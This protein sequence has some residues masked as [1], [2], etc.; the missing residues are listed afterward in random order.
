VGEIATRRTA[1]VAAT[2]VLV[3]SMMLPVAAGALSAGAAASASPTVTAGSAGSLGVPVQ[4]TAPSAVPLGGG[5]GVPVSPHP[6]TL[7]I[8]EITAGGATTEDPAIAYDTVSAEPILNVYEPLITY[9]GNQNTSLLPVLATCVPGT[10]QCVTDYGSSLID[11][12]NSMPYTGAAGQQPIYWTFVIDPAAHFYDNATGKSWGVYP[13]DVMFSEAR[14]LAFSEIIGS[15]NTAGWLTAQALLPAGTGWDAGGVHSPYNN[16]PGDIMS[17]MLIND[18]A[19]CPSTAI[20]NAHGCITFKADG[21]G[22]DWPFFLQ[23]IGDEFAG[24]VLPCGFFS[25]HHSGIPGWTGSNA[26]NGDGPCAVPQL[27]HSQS[28]SSIAWSDYLANLTST[29]SGPSNATSW[30]A[31]EAT[32]SGS[33]Y[34]VPSGEGYVQWHMAGSGPYYAATN[35]NGSP[36]GYVLG[37]NPAYAQPSGCSGAGGLA[38][39]SGVCYPAVGKYIPNA[40]IIYQVNSDTVGVNACKAKTADFCAFLTVDAGEMKTLHS[41]GLVN[42]YIAHSLSTFFQ[43]IDLNWSV[44]SFTSIGNTN[45]SN[46][47]IGPQFFSGLAARAFLQQS[48][49]YLESEQKAWTQSGIPFEFEAGGPIA[50]GMGNFYPTNVTF[51]LGNADTNPSDVGGAAWWWAQ[52]T[53]PSSQYYDPQLAACKVTKCI[54]PIVGELADPS[55]DKAYGYWM[56]SIRTITG[57]ALDPYSIDVPFAGAVNSLVGQLSESPGSG[58]Y[59][60]FTLGWA[61]DNFDPQ[62]YMAPMAYPNNTYT[63]STAVEEQMA[64]KKFNS[65]SCGHATYSSFADLVYWAHQSQLT[66]ACQGVAWQVMSYWN[67]AATSVANLTQRILDYNLVEHILNA[68]ALIVWQGQANQVTTAAPWIAGNSINFNQAVGGGNDQFWFEIEYAASQ[69]TVTFTETGLPVGSSFSVSAGAQDSGRSANATTTTALGKG[70]TGSVG[71]NLPKGTIGFNVTAPSGYGL[72]YVL[73]PKGTPKGAGPGYDFANV[74][75]NTT[76]TLV[77]GAETTL[78]FNEVTSSS[79]PGL[80]PGDQWSVTLVG[81]GKGAAPAQLGL[82]SGT[83]IVFNVAKGQS[84]KWTVGK[85]AAYKDGGSK[86]GGVKVGAKPIAKSVKFKLFGSEVTFAESGLKK[87]TS[88]WVD[89][90]GPSGSNN[91]S[92]TKSSIKFL[93]TNGTY[94]YA[95]G[96]GSAKP[97]SSGPVPAFTPPKG[98]KVKIVF[99]G[100]PAAVPSGSVT[101]QAASLVTHPNLVATVAGRELA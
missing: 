99:S 28:T 78:T 21:L 74:T 77:F 26:A 17:S 61:P 65:P 15:G 12:Q 46:I 80:A 33:D 55:L 101:R 69:P 85:P 72:A 71:F 10:P 3:L 94:T 9:N 54:F 81:H 76:F 58:A 70:S 50:I 47:S 35:P 100:A 88:W 5:G 27:G 37:V 29:A 14:Y 41:E 25:A 57:G 67:Q 4:Q 24:A 1:V 32:L 89:V 7:E 95:A 38:V 52:G 45:N 98:E 66:S 19:Y 53:N 64:L 44:A 8:Y 39:Y 59:P 22:H 30:D 92:S 6:G 51:P 20:T 60:V 90:T 96:T 23:L 34:P 42:Y 73:G 56:N 18:S 40:E 31:Y 87:G 83:S 11:D 2:L 63:Y 84:L 75:G 91:V 48:Y 68:E 82:T 49:D 16:T 93:L 79:W 97:V 62:D 36:G 13:T 86:K 43:P